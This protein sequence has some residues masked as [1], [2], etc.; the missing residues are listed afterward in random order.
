M[1]VEELVVS[2]GEGVDVVHVVFDDG[3]EVVVVGV[4]DFSFLEVD[5]GV[6]GGAADDG[7]VRV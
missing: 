4:G 1:V 7:V 6:L 5:V 2:A 3:R